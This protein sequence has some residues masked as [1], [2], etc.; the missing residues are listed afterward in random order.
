MMMKEIS[1]KVKARYSGYEWVQVDG[2]EQ[3]HVVN[4]KTELN[5]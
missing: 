3:I 5:L 2:D 4:P 1:K